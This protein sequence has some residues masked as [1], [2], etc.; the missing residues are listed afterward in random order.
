VRYIAAPHR[1]LASEVAAGRFRVDL[2]YRLDGVSLVIPPLRERRE[3][4]LD[5]RPLQTSNSR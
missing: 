2:Y 3:L 5:G 4:R 1:D